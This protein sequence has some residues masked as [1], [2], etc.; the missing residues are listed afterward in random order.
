MK[1]TKVYSD[2]TLN[3]SSVTLTTDRRNSE[4]TSQ[5][6]WL[7]VNEEILTVPELIYFFFFPFFFGFKTFSSSRSEISLWQ[8]CRNERTGNDSMVIPHTR[9]TGSD[10]GIVLCSWWWI[11][12]WSHDCRQTGHPSE[13]GQ[14]REPGLTIKSKTQGL[15]AISIP[16]VNIHLDSPG[17]RNRFKERKSGILFYL[18]L[19]K[20]NVLCC[21][22]L[23]TRKVWKSML[24]ACC[25]TGSTPL[26]SAVSHTASLQV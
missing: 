22:S 26:W 4:L 23:T 3:D 24:I 7:N 13:S 14:A 18:S 1:S 12:R 19:T 11:L 9:W 16:V 25:S 5:T 8:T 20:P 2:S 6:E 21:W 10:L 17:T 15:P